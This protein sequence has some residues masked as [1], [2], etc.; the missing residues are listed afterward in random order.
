MKTVHSFVKSIA[1]NNYRP[2]HF[3]FDKITVESAMQTSNNSH[4]TSLQRSETRFRFYVDNA[5]ENVHR[6]T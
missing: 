2:A 5:S 4:A 3:Q 6:Y 1:L